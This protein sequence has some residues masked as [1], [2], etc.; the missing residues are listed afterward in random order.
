MLLMPDKKKIAT[1]IVAGAKPDFVQK[2]G[3]KSEDPE[4]DMDMAEDEESNEGLELAAVAVSKAVK[5][6]DAK[7]LVKALKAFIQMCDDD[8]YED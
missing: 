1:L 2:F 8:C 6:D 3:E 4:I 7:K 5:A